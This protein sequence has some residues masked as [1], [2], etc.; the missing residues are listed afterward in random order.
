MPKLVHNHLR[1]IVEIIRHLS[2]FRYIVCPFLVVAIS[3]KPRR[4]L[5][6]E[7]LMFKFGIFTAAVDARDRAFA[8]VVQASSVGVPVTPYR[9]VRCGGDNFKGY[10][11]L[12]CVPGRCRI[13][14]RSR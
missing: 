5:N 6:P 3:W 14:H 8:F 7:L 4:E 13:A 2:D 9:R 11:G 10:V 12:A 1:Q